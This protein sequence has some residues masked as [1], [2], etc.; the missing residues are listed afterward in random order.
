M[1]KCFNLCLVLVVPAFHLFSQT[2]PTPPAGINYQINYTQEELS[3]YMIPEGISAAA[4]SPLD[5]MKLKPRRRLE[6]V[7]RRIA[8]DGT[9]SSTVTVLNPEEQYADW[10]YKV[11][12]IETDMSGTRVYKTDGSLYRSMPADAEELTNYQ[13]L[14]NHFY[15]Q[16]PPVNST[17]PMPSANDLIDLQA[18]GATIFYLPGNALRIR[19]G[20]H[21]ALFEPLL[22]QTTQTRYESQSVVEKRIQKYDYN[23]QGVVVP[24]FE[25]TERNIVR[26]SGACMQ[27]V[28]QRRFSNYTILYRPLERSTATAPATAGTKIWPNP[29]ADLF[30]IQIDEALQPEGSIRVTN[31]MGGLMTELAAQTGEILTIPIAHWPDG[32]YLIQIPESKGPRTV[33]LV[34][35]SR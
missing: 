11:G 33:K 24:V 23:A 31:A 1:Y 6:N 26:P 19:L 25:R 20:E 14:K 35:Q 12:R 2:L 34:K 21:E 27:Q 3:F 29:A 22:M 17:Y 8:T 32:V 16:L 15:N 5:Q 4:L 18:T 7:E 30:H 9:P 13:N 10:P 28:T